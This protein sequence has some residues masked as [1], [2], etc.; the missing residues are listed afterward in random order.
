[1]TMTALFQIR[2]PGSRVTTADQHHYPFHLVHP[3]P[4]EVAITFIS[5]RAHFATWPALILS[6]PGPSR[7]SIK[8]P[9][10]F[11]FSLT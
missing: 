3:E 6:P 10:P 11:P 8:R 5:S 4:F 9:I 1:M 2:L 7:Y